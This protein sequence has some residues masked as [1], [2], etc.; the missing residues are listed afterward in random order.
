MMRG[1]LKILA[2][3][4]GCWFTTA[5]QAVSVSLKC[6][7]YPDPSTRS[8]LFFPS[9][10]KVLDMKTGRPPGE[11][12]PKT[13]SDE[14][15]YSKV[16][17]GDDERLIIL[18]RNNQGDEYCSLLYFDRDGDG[19]FTR[20]DP[21]IVADVQPSQYRTT[22]SFPPLDVRIKVDGKAVPYSF[23]VEMNYYEGTTASERLYVRLVANCCYSG[24]LRLAGRQFRVLLGDGNVNGRF[25]DRPKVPDDDPDGEIKDRGDLFFLAPLGT[26]MDNRHGSMLGDIMVLGTKTYKV[27]ASS[28]N[29]KLVLTP[30]S[31]QMGTMEMPMQ[32]TFMSLYG[33][34]EKKAIVVVAPGKKVK[35]PKDTYRLLEY[36]V[37][38]NDQ[39]GDLWYLAAEGTKETP[40]IPVEKETATPTFG[41]P[42]IPSADTRQSGSTVRLYF[43]LLGSAKELVSEVLH[44][45]GNRTKIP[46]TTGNRPKEASYKIVS[47]EG[48][49]VSQGTFR[50]G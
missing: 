24:I 41:Q 22:V 32:V 29:K 16:Q 15:M 37:I 34:K 10:S 3:L 40:K 30:S 9:L 20:K 14:A 39:Q 33:T 21:P 43:K 35:I 7:K 19:K 23:R 44:L 50:Y 4:L 6:E 17:L 2:L 27:S 8:K 1:Y 12:I 13:V 11:G 25:S 48:R 45:E 31:S 49:L 18:D 36:R 28:A 38:C 42:F 5:A 47:T 26:N 46:L